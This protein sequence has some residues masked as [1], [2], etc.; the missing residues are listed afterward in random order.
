MRSENEPGS[1]PAGLLAR[2]RILALVKSGA[3]AAAAPIEP[4]Q[5]QPA[6][7][8]LR[9]GAEAFRVRASFLPGRGT[10]VAERLNSL[11]PERVSLEGDGAVLE[12]GIAYIAPL[13]ERFKLLAMAF[14]RMGL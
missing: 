5:L 9:L 8:D 14:E 4:G 7:L 10:S 11:N 6:S 2:Q 3:V 13:M 12:K 1:R